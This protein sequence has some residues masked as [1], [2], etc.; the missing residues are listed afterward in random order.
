M[1]EFKGYGKTE[2]SRYNF[3]L[4][5][6]LLEVQRYITES[7]LPILLHYTCAPVLVQSAHNVRYASRYF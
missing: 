1:E 7:Y 4:R 3:N 5:E 6:N 2:R